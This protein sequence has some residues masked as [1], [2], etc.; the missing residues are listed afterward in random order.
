[1]LHLFCA[2]NFILTTIISLIRKHNLNIDLSLIL[3]LNLNLGLPKK[4]VSFNFSNYSLI[5]IKFNVK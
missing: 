4:L 5:E 3:N 1:M 2:N